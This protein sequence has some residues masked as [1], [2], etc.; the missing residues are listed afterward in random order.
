MSCTIVLCDGS[1]FEDQELHVLVPFYEL[2]VA[3][4]TLPCT[5]LQRE[6]TFAGTPASAASPD[7]RIRR[8]CLVLIFDCTQGSE[9]A[10]CVRTLLW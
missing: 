1:D 5:N 6:L 3:H 8:G 9:Q 10:A 4:Q 2:L 7:F